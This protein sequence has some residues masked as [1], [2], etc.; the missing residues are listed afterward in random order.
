MFSLRRDQCQDS[1]SIHQRE[2]NQVSARQTNSG[3]DE[4]TTTQQ[5]VEALNQEYWCAMIHFLINGM[6][7]VASKGQCFCFND[8][9]ADGGLTQAGLIPD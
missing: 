6:Q 8:D 2:R 1:C 5:I 4:A 9:P 7:V 3:V